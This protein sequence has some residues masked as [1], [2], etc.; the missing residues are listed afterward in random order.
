MP[1][2]KSLKFAKLI[3]RIAGIWGFLVLTPLYFIFD[4]IGVTDPPPITH[5]AFFYG[6]AGVALAWQIA[7]FIIATDPAHY[8]AFMIPSCLEKFGYGGGVVILYT[9]NRVHP[10]DL[11]FGLADLLFAALFVVAYSKTARTTMRS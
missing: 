9:Q 7:F 3:F 1:N 4:R 2:P 8:R 10:A 11:S 6:F 5:P